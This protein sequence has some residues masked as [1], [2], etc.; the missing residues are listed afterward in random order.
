MY[1]GT[2]NKIHTFSYTCTN[3][4]KD[5]QRGGTIDD[6]ERL[7]KRG[8][9]PDK[10]KSILNSKNGQFFDKLNEFIR[11]EYNKQVELLSD[12]QDARI[13]VQAHCECLFHWEKDEEVMNHILPSLDGILFENDNLVR[14]IL[15]YKSSRDVD[16]KLS[17]ITQPPKG[18]EGE[19]YT[20]VV[21]AAAKRIRAVILSH[22]DYYLNF[23]Q[24]AKLFCYQLIKHYSSDYFEINDDRGDS[25]EDSFSIKDYVTVVS[26][27][28][29]LLVPGITREFYNL[30]GHN[31][32]WNI[33]SRNINNIGIVY[34]SFLSLWNLSFEDESEEHFSNAE[35]NI[36]PEIISGLK[37]ISKEKL[38]KIA[39]RIFKNIARWPKCIELM[40]DN[41]LIK[42]IENEL[43]KNIKDEG[44]RTNLEFLNDELEKNYRIASS[45]EKYKKELETGKLSWGPC[46]NEK[47][48][49]TNGRMFSENDYESIKKI[50]KLLSESKDTR[51]LAVACYDLGEFCRYVPHSRIILET[52]SHDQIQES[53]GS[54][55][56]GKQ[57]LMDKIS[58]RDKDV[59]EQALLAT[60]KMMIHNWQSVKA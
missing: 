43:K 27:S 5:N 60:Q 47:F 28:H 56:S 22:R 1:T 31:L 6:I 20:S 29:L 18:N 44:L 41:D 11:A 37:M 57:L 35:W 2:R 8:G 50:L 33:M 40:N 53:R 25:N 42:N 15:E 14:Y 51:T 16:L 45:Y 26:F 3:S 19:R 10:E 59:K 54:G 21:V 7:F 52:T 13:I 30:K 34:Y 32:L 49:K 17:Q 24:D 46:H 58:H 4:T 39:F 48:W 12:E 36:I 9:L 38:S 55:K 23:G